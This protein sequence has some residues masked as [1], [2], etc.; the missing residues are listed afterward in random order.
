MNIALGLYMT[1]YHFPSQCLESHPT[2]PKIRPH[3]K[4]HLQVLLYIRAVEHGRRK[5]SPLIFIVFT[6]LLVEHYSNG[7][8]RCQKRKANKNN[9]LRPFYDY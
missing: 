2:L 5:M 9:Q 6:T 8:K 1:E 3:Q 7:G 4:Y